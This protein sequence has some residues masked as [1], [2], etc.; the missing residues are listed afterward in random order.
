MDVRWSVAYPLSSRH[1]AALLEER[2]VPID[3]ATSQRG[4]VKASPLLAEAWHRRKRPVGGSWRMD[5]PSSKGQG[6]WED[7]S[8][9]VETTGQP[10]DVLRT[11]QR[12]EQGA[13]RFLTKA[14]RRPG[15]PEKSPLDGS[16]A[17]EAALQSE[18]AEHGTAI[19][20]RQSTYLNNMV[21]QESRGVKRGTRPMAGLKSFEAAQD[22]L[23]GIELMPLIQKRQMRVEA[24]AEGRTAA[25]LC[26]SL[27][28]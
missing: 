4:V 19:A 12:D 3:H 17:K 14:I 2:G 22:T 10:M 13:Q 6:P 5:E 7:L 27:A 8:R 20:I 9:A 15:G 23:V 11:E 16:A 28:A 25:A 26:Y 1:V 21:E 24:G 18:H